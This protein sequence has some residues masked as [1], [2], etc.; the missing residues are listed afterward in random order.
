MRGTTAFEWLDEAIGPLD[1][2]VLA[3]LSELDEVLGEAALRRERG[4]GLHQFRRALCERGFGGLDVPERSG[5]A[6]LGP[7]EQLMVQVLCGW[8]DADFRDIAHV[9]HGNLLLRH[10]SAEQRAIWTPRLLNGALVAIATTERQG[11]SNVRRANT[12]LSRLADRL[13]IRGE[14]TF[15]SRIEEAD[16]IVVF[17]RHD[18]TGD[19]TAVCVPADAHGVKR[20]LDCPE[21]LR[22]WSWGTLEFDDVAVD[23]DDVLPG[24]GAAIFR[25]HLAYYRPLVAATVVGAAA[26]VWEQAANDLHRRC[27]SKHIDRVRDSALERLAAAHIALQGALLSAMRAGELVERD[28]PRAQIWS[29]S[30]KAHCVETAYNAAE[31]TARLLGARS[32][33]AESVTAKALRD[34][35]GYLY[36]DGMHDALLR[37]AGRELLGVTD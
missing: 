28:D 22:G 15:V 23:P 31:D 6:G 25:A 8:H 27:V 21:G 3:L 30:A 11:G 35:R 5:G 7:R 32:F 2:R 10:G 24:D 29:R 14:K 13:V 19:L 18:E 26:R 33:R 1:D 9:G 12:I 34:I 37:S 16:A 17:C 36:A 20:Q 4:I